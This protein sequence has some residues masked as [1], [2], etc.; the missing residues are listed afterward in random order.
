MEQG[1]NLF[2]RLQWLTKTGKSVRR[3]VMGSKGKAGCGCLLF[4]LVICMVCVGI[5]IH[6][7]TLK[8]IGGQ[9]VYQDKVFPSDVLFVPRFPED[10]SGELYAEAFR[11]FWAGNGKTIWIEDDRI[12]GM[13]ILDIV[14]KMAKSR[15][16]PEGTLKKLEVEGEGT[17]K[18]NGIEA[19]F[20]KMGAKRV[21]ILVPEYASRRFHMIYGSLNDGSKVS[22][23]IKPVNVSY[24]KKDRWWK[25]SLS[26]GM[27]FREAS[28]M[29]SYYIERFKY[30]EKEDSK[31]R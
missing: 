25:E 18:I 8:T 26:R 13:S 5:F 3:G 10:S 11:E 16:V 2:L 21:I 15:G 17:A 27:L 14:A 20:S 12:L 4:L 7:F 1:G 31:K 23:L 30:G 9:L 29:V 28:Y 19:A 6:P 24:F 22:Y